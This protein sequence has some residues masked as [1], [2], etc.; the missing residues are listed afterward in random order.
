MSQRLFHKV[1]QNISTIHCGQGGVT[2]VSELSISDEEKVKEVKKYL[3]IL[4]QRYEET[5]IILECPKN[6]QQEIKYLRKYFHI[7]KDNIN[8]MIKYL[9]RAK[10]FKNLL[11]KNNR[12]NY[13]FEK[14][15]LKDRKKKHIKSFALNEYG[16]TKSTY[17]RYKESLKA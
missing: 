11:K 16:I 17:Y 15:I 14:D 3:M 13:R 1:F 9:Q 4:Q 6:I 7:E 12:K 8:N 2:G 5:G 10:Y